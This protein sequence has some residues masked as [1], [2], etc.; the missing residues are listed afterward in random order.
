MDLFKF[1]DE[2]DKGLGTF[3][4]GSSILSNFKKLDSANDGF[5]GIGSGNDSVSSKSSS[6]S[7]SSSS[8]SSMSSSSSSSSSSSEFSCFSLSKELYYS[9]SI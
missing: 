3:D 1:L 6:S 8:D 5:K 7:S 9:P 2:D 4:F